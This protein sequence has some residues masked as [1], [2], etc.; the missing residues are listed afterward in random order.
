MYALF[1][2]IPLIGHLNPL[3]RQAVELKRRGW[4]VAIACAGDM[5][6]H[7]SRE[8]AVP[9]I[10]LGGL[11]PIAGELR[12]REEAASLDANLIR[13]TLGILDGLTL[14]WPM[15]FD[16][17]QA[18]IAADR[19]DVMVVD[20]FTS[21]G[22]AAAEQANIPVV[23]NNA[24][25]LS[26]VPVTLL[27]PADH[28]PYLFSGRSVHSVN[29]LQKV[30]G[31][32]I[33]KL[34]TIG[35]QFSVGRKQNALRQSRGLPPVRFDAP[36][37]GKTILVDGVFGLEYE[38]PLPD[39]IHMV[40]PMLPPV[41][42]LPA[43]LDAWLSNGPPVVYANLG[44]LA[45]AP[46]EL[47]QAIAEALSLPG[48]RALWILKKAQADRLPPGLPSS[49]RVMEWGPQPFAILSHPNV[50]VFVS[51]CGINSAHESIAAGTPIAG[52]PMFADQRDMAVR[53]ADAGVGTWF[54][55]RA[56]TGAQLG[57]AIHSLMRDAEIPARIARLQDLIART[58]GV[59]KAADCIA[60][61]ARGYSRT[62]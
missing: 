3:I 53:I 57:S 10:D 55:K 17:L 19:P 6:A 38:R 56:L 52:I 26:V 36:L 47:L 62:A 9:F 8:A 23:V 34:A 7:V 54:D 41:E 61:A 44:T 15:M 58:G 33:R 16:G 1:T 14:V 43:D 35:A 37:A 32:A 22:L 11:G 51:H 42:P 46:T 30:F 5:R 13:G 20:M 27:P 29:P 21:A 31:P 60:A 49:L 18:V 50:K 40:G 39:H 48:R 2:S 59:S 45:V 25:L 28:L 12:R 24:D 4:R